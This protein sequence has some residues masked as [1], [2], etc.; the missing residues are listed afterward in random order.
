MGDEAD[1]LRLPAAVITDDLD[2]E[3]RIGG[4]TRIDLGE[5]VLR[6]T[7]PEER[8]LPHRPVVL[9]GAG[10]LDIFDGR[11]KALL[12]QRLGELPLTE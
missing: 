5:H 9:A 10:L 11:H 1:R 2:V 6:R 12:K 7:Y 8:G 4:L 3:A